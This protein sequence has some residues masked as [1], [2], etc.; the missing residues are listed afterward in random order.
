MI[1][2]GKKIQ[3]KKMVMIIKTMETNQQMKDGLNVQISFHIEDYPDLVHRIDKI[4]HCLDHV[5]VDQFLE[6]EGEVDQVQEIEGDLEI[7]IDIDPDLG[8][9]VET[10][11]EIEKNHIV[12]D[13]GLF[14]GIGKGLIIETKANHVQEVVVVIN[15]EV[16]LIRDRGL[17]IAD[18]N[19]LKKLKFQLQRKYFI[20]HVFPILNKSYHSIHSLYFINIAKKFIDSTQ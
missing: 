19:V 4:A 5:K 17:R 10:G 9:V 20:F 6:N 13:L 16:D 2:L 7:M 12:V 11:I 1:S 3:K 15:I 18:V 8:Q 14:L